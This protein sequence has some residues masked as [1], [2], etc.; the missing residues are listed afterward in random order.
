MLYILD[1]NLSLL[2]TNF[3]KKKIDLK[4][5]KKKK[6]KYVTNFATLYLGKVFIFLNEFIFANLI[7]TIMCPM[8]VPQYMCFMWLLMSIRD[9]GIFY[10]FIIN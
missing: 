10:L 5:W 7:V 2:W 9:L 8:Y 6:K 1:R 4:M 3:S